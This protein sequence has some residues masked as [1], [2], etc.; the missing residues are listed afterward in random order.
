MFNRDN[1]QTEQAAEPRPWREPNLR[2]WKVR[3]W[4]HVPDTSVLEEITVVAHGV[5]HANDGVIV[6][7]RFYLDPVLGPQPVPIRAFA[8]FYDYEDVTPIEDDTRLIH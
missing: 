6:F 3:R 1:E 8:S 7:S 5:T 2:T 4:N